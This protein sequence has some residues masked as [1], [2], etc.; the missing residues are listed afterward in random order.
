MSIKISVQSQYHAALMMLK[1]AVEKCPEEL[2][3]AEDDYV[4]PFWHVAYH[5]LFYTHFYLSPTEKDFIPWEQHR[6]EITSLETSVK[7]V[8]PYNTEA[9][10]EYLEFCLEQVE[11]QLSGMDLEAESGFY[12]LPFEK[13]ELQFYNIRHIQ[14]HTGELCERLGA[15]GEIEVPW[16]GMKR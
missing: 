13:L 12:W 4:N 10:L 1:Q 15:H 6:D 2:W 7:E 14:Q 3:A 11:V 5:V 9:I 16:V 8:Q